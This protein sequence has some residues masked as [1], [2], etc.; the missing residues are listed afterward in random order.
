[1]SDRRLLGVWDPSYADAMD[2]H[3]RMLL[4]NIDAFRGDGITDQDVYVWPGR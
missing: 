3:L 4:A 1:V 2:A